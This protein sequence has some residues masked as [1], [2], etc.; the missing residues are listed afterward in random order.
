MDFIPGYL[1]SFFHSSFFVTFGGKEETTTKKVESGRMGVA[2]STLGPLDPRFSGDMDDWPA[3][4]IV[5]QWT[6]RSE[7][8]LPFFAPTLFLLVDCPRLDRP[9]LSHNEITLEPRPPLWRKKRS[10]RLCFSVHWTGR[11][12]V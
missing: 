1:R 4:L 9:R 3:Y 2:T 11:P 6:F 10:Q 12:I 8:D 7:S 5:N